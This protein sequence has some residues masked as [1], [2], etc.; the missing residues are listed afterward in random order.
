[1]ATATAPSPRARSARSATT[2]IGVAGVNW[3]VQIMPV[4]FLNSSGSGSDIAAAE[5][6]D[7]AVNMGAKVINAS[8]GGSGWDSTIASAISYANQHGVIVVCA[9]GNNSSNDDT[10]PFSPASYSATYANVISVASIN[11]DGTLSSW[12][13]YGTGTV[14]LA[15]PGNSIY[16]TEGSGYAYDSGTSMAAPFV[17]GAVALV[18]AAHPT[19]SMSQVVDAIVNTTTPDPNLAGK[20]TTGGILNAAAAVAYTGGPHV[21]AASPSG[22]LTGSSSLSSVQLTFNEEINPATFTASQASLTG[23]SGAIV[24]LTVTPVSGSNNHQF[25]VSFPSQSTAGTYTLKVGPNIQD[26][27]GNAM[28]QNGNL[29]TGEAS[30]AFTDTM[31]LTKTGSSDL[32][33]V[34]S[35]PTTTKA[36]T[37]QTITVSALT[38]SGSVDTSYTGTVQFSSSDPS[39]VLPANYTFTASDQG[40]HTFTTAATLDTAGT[41]SITVTDTKK[42]SIIGAEEGIWV[43]GAT[44]HSLVI[45][46]LPTSA[47]AGTSLGLTVTALDQF[48]NV[49]SGYGGTIA[50][51]STDAQAVLPSSYAYMIENGGTFSFTTTLET[52]G[53]QTIKVTDSTNGL[54]VTSA[55]S[56]SRPRPPPRWQ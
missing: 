21:T 50:F 44:A 13:N 37:A 32:L 36:G 1:M 52:A 9:A 35:F 39:A 5:A 53:S 18:E 28:N 2:A 11:S 49:A 12:S 40:A 22:A 29:V 24:G 20:V 41:Q 42:S 7:Y 25:T 3:N 45:S 27:Y 34:T 17:T 4:A 26:W 19:W 54:S 14:Q 16:S 43:T 6:I 55:P 47:T 30:D 23:P 38:P 46:G 56:R 8:W 15:A 31:Y 48:G 10:T 33:S 51:T